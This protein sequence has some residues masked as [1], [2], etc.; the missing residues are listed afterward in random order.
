MNSLRVLL[1]EDDEADAELIFR[2]IKRGGYVVKASQI[3]STETEFA[4]A[5]SKEQWDVVLSDYNLPG[6]GATTALRIMK[7]QGV[8]CP[9]MVVSGAIGEESAID[10][11]LAGA[12]DFIH[13]SNL[14]RLS[15]S[16]GR[17]L[18]ERNLR[19]SAEAAL[20]Q[21]EEMLAIV[22]HDLKNPVG[23]IKLTTQMMRK[24]LRAEAPHS[25]EEKF[26][27]FTSR[28]ENSVAQMEHLI[29]DLLD[30]SKMQEGKFHVSC[31]FNPVQN[32]L[33][34]LFQSFEPLANQKSIKLSTEACETGSSAFFDPE[35]ILQ[36]LSNLVG[37]AIKFTPEGG[38]VSV[39]VTSSKDEIS[40]FVT[41]S[42][43]GIPESNIARI[44]D[45]Y[46]QGPGDERRGA[47]LGLAIAKGIVDA[48]GGKIGV[49]SKLGEGSTFHF[50]IPQPNGNRILV[51]EDDEDLLEIYRSLLSDQGYTPTLTKSAEEAL[52]QFDLVN[53]AF[54]LVIADGN[55]PGMSGSGL[56]KAIRGMKGAPSQIPIVIASAENQVP[57]EIK[58][59]VSRV[60][61]KP[62]DF[63]VLLN[64]DFGA[65]C[66]LNPALLKTEEP[67]SK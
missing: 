41:D 56:V 11:M 39:G 8:N 28:L 14:L 37:N 65:S 7:E 43:P 17:C 19:R 29:S 22:S 62:L 64:T 9:F 49:R 55:L 1:V 52:Q 23:T 20:R 32:L 54:R 12:E 60:L 13:K 18:R 15:R 51:V 3:V 36:V 34:R 30:Y 10:L 25:R 21:R 50:S 31:G 16:L 58:T 4:A 46:W 2:E 40:F 57:D 53:P 45:K 61:R 42:G 63:D 44:F 5:L 66:R 6:F 67:T 33:L 48:H 35:R 47:G 59:L 26:L 27:D 24:H 38:R